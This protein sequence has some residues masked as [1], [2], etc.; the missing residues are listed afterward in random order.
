[1][2][3][4]QERPKSTNNQATRQ[5]SPY[6]GD[7]RI[8]RVT[9]AVRR[10]A[11]YNFSARASSKIYIIIDQSAKRKIIDPSQCLQSQTRHMRRP[12]QPKHRCHAHKQRCMD[13]SIDSTRMF[14]FSMK[15]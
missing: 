11:K 8:D 10:V 2:Y 15:G 5:S 6:L 14:G 12:I 4:T 3:K 13:W 1:M 7:T 9:T